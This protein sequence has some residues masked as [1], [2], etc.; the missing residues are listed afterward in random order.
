[1]RRLIALLTLSTGLV[2]AA[3]AASAQECGDLTIASMNWQ[4][5]ELAASLDRFILNNGYGCNAEIIQ[6]DTVP[7]ITSMVEKGEP[8][9][10][11]EGW[12]D[13]VPEVIQAGIADGKIV[14]TVDILS[15]GAV[16]GWWIPKYIA[17]AN[18]DLKT[19]DDVLKRPD[20]FPDPEDPSKGAVHNG[21]QGWGGTVVTGQLYRAFGGEAAGFTLVDTGSAAGLDGSIARAYEREQGWVGYYWAPTALLG[22]YEMVKLDHGVE[23]DKDQW[24]SCTS[25][26]ECA[27]PKKNDWP[28]DRVQTVV[29]K[30]FADAAPAE[31]MDYLGKRAWTNATVNGVM[32]WMTDNQATGD[33]GA[34]HFLK[35]NEDLWK[36][37]VSAEAAEKI[38]SAL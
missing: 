23:L 33:E 31:V 37:W 15:D 4:S 22:K 27:D 28:K 9:I 17:E 35:E 34:V 20:L 11:P 29:V 16:Q 8:Q 38:K 1:M 32:A 10:A 26:A 6:G 7:T 13:L 12:V 18:P 14:T 2:G 3:S 5:A 19:I 21:P 24:T 30:S 36:A 25:N